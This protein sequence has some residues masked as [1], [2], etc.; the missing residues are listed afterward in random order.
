M[1]FVLQKPL[2]LYVS[3]SM[4]VIPGERVA[5]PAAGPGAVRLSA[6]AAAVREKYRNKLHRVQAELS[7]AWQETSLAVLAKTRMEQSC[8]SVQVRLSELETQ[9]ASSVASVRRLEA[10]V[11]MLSKELRAKDDDLANA[12]TERVKAQSVVASALAQ[13]ELAQRREL[14]LSA[15]VLDLEAA[16]DT[17]TRQVRDHEHTIAALHLR[18]KETALELDELRHKA[19]VHCAH[20]AVDAAVGDVNL[21]SALSARRQ[22]DALS[23]DYAL[24][25][26]DFERAHT[27]AAQAAMAAEDAESMAIRHAAAAAS[28]R[29]ERTQWKRI[30]F[31]LERRLARREASLIVANEQ[32]VVNRARS[33]RARQLASPDAEIASLRSEVADL[34]A[35]NVSL[36]V[37]LDAMEDAADIIRFEAAERARQQA[38]AASEDVSWH[39]RACVVLKAAVDAVDA[40]LE[41]K[42]AASLKQYELVSMD[43][44]D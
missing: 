31:S 11:T 20:A 39:D 16:R 22:L 38:H 21:D 35:N 15:R 34:V 44:I 40:K 24:L 37:K 26:R 30:L 8:A 12:A 41:S 29:A 23:Y 32:L 1:H 43:C 28:A 27:E 18:L 19:A 6:Q 17:V 4:E 36:R 14:A 33:S 25:R 5:Q 2:D 13:A 9:Q 3:E 10:E 7:K 42:L